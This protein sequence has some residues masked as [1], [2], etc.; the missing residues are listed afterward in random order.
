MFQGK[1]QTL[2]IPPAILRRS[3]GRG[4]TVMVLN[5]VSQTAKNATQLLLATLPPRQMSGFGEYWKQNACNNHNRSGHSN[6][7]TE[8]A[9]ETDLYGNWSILLLNKQILKALVSRT[10][11]F[12]KPGNGQFRQLIRAV[13][14]FNG[15]KRRQK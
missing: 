3:N 4:P 14:N 7:L 11:K 10:G 2:R 12:D 5:V 6:H 15:I 9:P 13:F 1:I 8:I